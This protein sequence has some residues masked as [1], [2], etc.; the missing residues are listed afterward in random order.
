MSGRADPFC[1]HA[2]TQLAM[3]SIREMCA[4]D[5]MSHAL[6]H[7]RAFFRDFSSL[8]SSVCVDDLPAPAIEGMLTDVPCEH[9]H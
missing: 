1:M 6:N 3:H 7:F 4:V 8:D 2:C 9:V 5:D